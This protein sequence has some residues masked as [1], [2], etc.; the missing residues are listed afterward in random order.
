[1]APAAIL[2]EDGEEVVAFGAEEILGAEEVLLRD[3]AT[4]PPT[5]GALMLHVRAVMPDG[6]AVLDAAGMLRDPRLSPF[7]RTEE[8]S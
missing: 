7:E 2:I 5:E 6:A 8:D 1:M 3:L 4:P